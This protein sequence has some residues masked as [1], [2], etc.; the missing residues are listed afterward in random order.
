MTAALSRMLQDVVP[1]FPIPEATS[2]LEHF[3][4][5]VQVVV[6]IATVA[7]VLIA[8]F[9]EPLRAWRNR[10]VLSV[11]PDA[12]PVRQQ[13]SNVA[14]EEL[15]L[16][17]LIVRNRGRGPASSVRAVLRSTQ[18][19]NPI[20]LR[21]AGM[22]GKEERALHMPSRTEWPLD[23]LTIHHYDPPWFFLTANDVAR[24]ANG[25]NPYLLNRTESSGRVMVP[26]A[27]SEFELDLLDD[28]S[29]LGEFTITLTPEKILETA[30]QPPPYL[31]VEARRPN[32][33]G[34][35]SVPTKA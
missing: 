5:V 18:F 12:R 11:R 3:N 32:K 15:W 30:T 2:P 1:T 10:P 17:R 21:W 6:A 23:L 20:S 33:N 25:G 34:A 24:A 4:A 13:V 29:L 8:L 7:A 14:P 22:L 19:P 9:H 35:T 16:V 26:L 27:V 28:E 31:H